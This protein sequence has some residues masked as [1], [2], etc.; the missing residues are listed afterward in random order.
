MA[1][2][3][4]IPNNQKLQEVLNSIC[5]ALAAAYNAGGRVLQSDVDVL[6]ED[7]VDDF[8]P[9]LVFNIAVN[10]GWI[11]F[12]VDPVVGLDHGLIMGHYELPDEARRPFVE[13]LAGSLGPL[14]ERAAQDESALLAKIETQ[15]AEWMQRLS[16]LGHSHRKQERTARSLIDQFKEQSSDAFTFKDLAMKASPYRRKIDG[17]SVSAASITRMYQGKYVEDST[18]E[19]VAQAL[20]AVLKLDPPV[21]RHDLLPAERKGAAK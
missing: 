8:I 10:A 6:T 7:A 4:E 1:H 15:R 19:A 14:R 18:R 5:Y 16:D 9:Q 21:S 3:C 13:F 2:G 17:A 20:N 12:Q 11:D